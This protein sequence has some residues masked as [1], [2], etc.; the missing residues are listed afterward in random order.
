[1]K[2]RNEQQDKAR[3]EERHSS[4]TKQEEEEA[5]QEAAREAQV[6]R[7]VMDA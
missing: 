5:R 6:G 7:P 4:K 3:A 1:L 2:E